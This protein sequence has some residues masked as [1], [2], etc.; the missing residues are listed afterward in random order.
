VL[1]THVALESTHIR[2]GSGWAVRTAMVSSAVPFDAR[3]PCPPEMITVLARMDGT[4]TV[5]ELYA[6][7]SAADSLA[8]GASIDRLASYIHM[9]AS[10]GFVEL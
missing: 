2:E 5:R 7:L 9:L 4:R 1:A 8:E 10:H 3:L 6:D